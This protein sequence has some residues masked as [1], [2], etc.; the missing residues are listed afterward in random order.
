MQQ[1][2]V[3][4]AAEPIRTTIVTD[5]GRPSDP[6]T[7]TITTPNRP[8]LHQQRTPTALAATTDPYPYAYEQRLAEPPGLRACFRSGKWGN[9]LDAGIASTFPVS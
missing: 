3:E 5:G 7:V 4:G 9:P 8:H 6:H 1:V 2:A